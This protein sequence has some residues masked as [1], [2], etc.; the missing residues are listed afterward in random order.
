MLDVDILFRLLRMRH[1]VEKNIR[2]AFDAEVEPPVTGYP[3]LPTFFV[4][5]LGRSEGWRMSSRRKATCFK[6]ARL[7][8][9]GALA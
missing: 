3:R 7:I 9:G 4:V 6:N 2:I 1:D 8:A 5:L